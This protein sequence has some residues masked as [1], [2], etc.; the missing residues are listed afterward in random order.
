M[1]EILTTSNR[2]GPPLLWVSALLLVGLIARLALAEYALRS[3][4]ERLADTELYLRYAQTIYEGAPYDAGGMRALRAPGYPLFVAGCW[5]LAGEPSAR[6]VL[7]AQ[8]LLGVMG[9]ALVYGLGRYFERQGAPAGIAL[10]AL[11]IALFE[12]YGLLLGILELSESLFSFLLLLGCWLL[13]TSIESKSLLR[14]LLT[15]I[16]LGSATLVRPSSLAIWPVLFAAI[17][18]AGM[19]HH[20]G[21]QWALCGLVGFL[22]VL[23]PWWVRNAAVLGAFVP[24]TTN[25]GESLFDGLNPRADGSSNFWFKTELDPGPL[26]E[27]QLDAHWRSEAI[28]WGASHPADVLRL[29]AIKLGRFW[30]PWPNEPRFRTPLILTATT[31]ITGIFY[32]LA[33]VGFASRE[34]GG[35]WKWGLLA[36]SLAPVLTLAIVHMV[37]VSSIRYR[38]VAMPLVALTAALGWRALVRRSRPA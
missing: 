31:S 25:V 27:R 5:T 34:P 20:A 15:G 8:A 9:A 24:T 21:R 38:A 35:T 2:L 14:S 26:S 7:W 23:G 4:P 33:L 3:V 32:L 1:N 37:F 12:P 17:F 36:I 6:A 30:S 19:T 13:V 16:T 28:A 10:A 22:L 11:T 18:L 29:A